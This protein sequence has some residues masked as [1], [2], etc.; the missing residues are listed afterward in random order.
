MYNIFR[1]ALCIC[2]FDVNRWQH[3]NERDAYFDGNYII[4]MFRR[5]FV[6]SCN[7]FLDFLCM[8]I[9]YIY[10]NQICSS[11]FPFR[12]FA[13]SVSSICHKSVTFYSQSP[14]T[15]HISNII[16][17]QFCQSTLTYALKSPH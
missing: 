4:M 8:K 17:C 6:F 3:L 12:C 15:Q 9:I 7:F 14:A 1:A 16:I 2:I 11:L 13:I 5:I 10:C